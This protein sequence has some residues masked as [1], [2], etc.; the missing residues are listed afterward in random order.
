[1]FYK[2]RDPNETVQMM[3][4]IKQWNAILG[5]DAQQ[6]RI[7]L[8]MEK[9]RFEYDMLLHLVDVVFLGKDIAVYWG[10]KNKSDAMQYFNNKFPDMYVFNCQIFSISY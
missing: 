10:C 1:M 8:D 9:T 4:Y 7:S 2:G 5:H 6:I 3:Q